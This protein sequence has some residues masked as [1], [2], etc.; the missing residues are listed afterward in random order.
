M[1]TT[2]TPIAPIPVTLGAAPEVLP[3]TAPIPSATPAE[4]KKPSR[5]VRFIDQIEHIAR[6]AVPVIRF[7]EKLAIAAEPELALTPFGPEYILCLNAI[8]GVQKVAGASLA[9]GKDLTAEQRFSLAAQAALPGLQTI[10]ASKGIT[11]PDA[12]AEAANQFLQ[13]V[14]NLQAGPVVAALPASTGA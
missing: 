6:A 7:G 13:N 14:Y 12:Q 3:P 9:A 10:L 8:L 11:I 4:A 5:F 1:S 2:T